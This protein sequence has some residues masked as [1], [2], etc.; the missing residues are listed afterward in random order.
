MA[1]VVDPD[2]VQLIPSESELFFR[3]LEM[4]LGLSCVKT[5][6]MC[7]IQGR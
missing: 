1:A 4:L 7:L 5:G 6:H 2:F 3:K